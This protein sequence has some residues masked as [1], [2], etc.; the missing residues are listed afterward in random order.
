MSVYRQLEAKAC[1]SWQPRLKASG[2]FL[3]EIDLRYAAQYEL[4]LSWISLCRAADSQILA[5][6]RRASMKAMP[7]F[8]ATQPGTGR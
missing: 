3:P 5:P 2:A 8:T 7:R 6:R 4:R 1:E